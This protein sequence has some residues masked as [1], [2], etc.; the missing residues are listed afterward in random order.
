M[1]SQR[2]L[3]FRDSLTTLVV[4]KINGNINPRLKAY[5]CI[6]IGIAYTTYDV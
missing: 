4:S 3:I 1:V 2:I 5:S 6:I